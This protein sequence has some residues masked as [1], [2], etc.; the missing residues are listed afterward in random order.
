MNLL[1][2][3]S[4]SVQPPRPQPPTSHPGASHKGQNVTNP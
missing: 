1:F 4:E 2:A 3:C